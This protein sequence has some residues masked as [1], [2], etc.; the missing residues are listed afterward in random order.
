MP[1]EDEIVR[2]G[3]ES[4]TSSYIK[5][6]TDAVDKNKALLEKLQAQFSDVTA[7][8]EIS[9]KRLNESVTAINKQYGEGAVNLPFFSAVTGQ[10]TDEVVKQNEALNRIKSTIGE[11]TSVIKQQTDAL[12]EAREEA[13]RLR[14]AQETVPIQE[15]VASPGQTPRVNPTVTPTT[16]ETAPAPT[17]AIAATPQPRQ[18]Q[19]VPSYVVGKEERDDALTLKAE[20][21]ELLARQQ[22]TLTGI[23]G[24]MNAETLLAVDA[25]N[26]LQRAMAE[27]SLA[28]SALTRAQKEIGAAASA[29]FAP[30][31]TAIQNFERANTQARSVVTSLEE[32]VSNLTTVQGLAAEGAQQQTA[33]Q[34]RLTYAQGV[35]ARMAQTLAD[36]E[37]EGT[38]TSGSGVEELSALRKRAM[39]EQQV[40]SQALVNVQKEIGAAAAAGEEPAI[41][42]IQLLKTSYA[43]ATRVVNQ[44]QQQIKASNAGVTEDPET[45]MLER[46]IAVEQQVAAQIER[47]AVLQT[48]SNAQSVTG[49]ELQNYLQRA[50]TESGV[51]AR[52][53]AEAQRE[54][55]TSAAQG[56]AQAL[57]I[58]AQLSEA[59]T[60]ARA[61]VDSLKSTIDQYRTS[62][63]GANSQAEA[64]KVATDQLASAQALASRQTETLSALQRELGANSEIS[65]SQMAAIYRRAS[66]ELTTVTSAL[67]N[68]QRE[69]GP[70]AAAGSVEAQAA[71]AILQEQ[72]AKTYEVVNQ[73]GD[74]LK[75]SEAA[76]RAGAEA[77]DMDSVAK[78]QLAA[79]T[80]TATRQT[81]ALDGIQAELN[82]SIGIS[83][84]QLGSVY[85][86][87]AT[88]ARTATTA[89]GNAQRILGPAVA[90]GNQE[91]IQALHLLS[92]A[93]QEAAGYA[94]MLQS[95]MNSLA[96]TEGRTTAAVRMEA[97]AVDAASQAKRVGAAATLEAA[98]A[99]QKL[100]YSALQ[101]FGASRVLASEAGLGGVGFVLSR[102]IS[103]SSILGPLFEALLPI[104][105]VGMAIG[106]FEEWGNK[107]KDINDNY[108]ELKGTMDAVQEVELRMAHASE[109]DFQRVVDNEVSHLKYL[110]QNVEAAELKRQSLQSKPVDLTQVLNDKQI[111]SMK[112]L[113]ED[114]RAKFKNVF[115]DMVAADVP[116]KLQSLSTQLTELE[117]KRDEI[118]KRQS[119]ETDVASPEGGAGFGT[120]MNERYANQVDVA[121]TLYSSAVQ[122]LQ[123][124]RRTFD[125]EWNKETDE[126]SNERGRKLIQ[127]TEE[128]IDIMK[129]S[130][131]Y[132]KEAEKQKWTEVLKQVEEGTTN[133]HTV[134][135]KLGRTVTTRGTE[136][137]HTAQ[138]LRKQDQDELTEM[139]LHGEEIGAERSKV[140]AGEEAYVRDRINAEY[141]YVDNV[142]SLRRELVQILQEEERERIKTENTKAR[143]MV[144]SEGKPDFKSQQDFWNQIATDAKK[145][146]DEYENAVANAQRAGGEAIRAGDE[147]LK[148]DIFASYDAWISATHRTQAEILKFWQNIKEMYSGSG[149]VVEEA[150]RKI[151]EATVKLR[152]ETEK[153]NRLKAEGQD[154]KKIGDLEEE[155]QKAERDSVLF[156]QVDDFPFKPGGRTGKQK[157][158]EIQ[159]NLD[160][161]IARQ[162]QIQ[163]AREVDQAKEEHGDDSPQYQ[164]ALN[165]KAEMDRRY[166]ALS[167]QI[168]TQRL[169]AQVEEYQK[170]FGIIE[171]G[172]N[173]AIDRL[174]D[175]DK[176]WYQ[177]FGDI[178]KNIEKEFAHMLI[179]IAMQW[180]ESKII[181]LILGQQPQQQKN[182]NNG[183]QQQVQQTKNANFQSSESYAGLAASEEFAY[184]IASSAGDIPYAMG[185][186]AIAYGLAQVWAAASQFKEGGLVPGDANMAVPAVLHGKEMVLPNHLSEG[187][188]NLIEGGDTTNTGPATNNVL[189]MRYVDQSTGKVGDPGTNTRNMMIQAKR[190]FKSFNKG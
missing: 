128:E 46:R 155:K 95:Q 35:A 98:G 73:Y 96:E 76:E 169:K 18:P 175:G 38:A 72:Y 24:E 23:T 91:A 53:L 29:N 7:R 97:E 140:L 125:S 20:S 132:T 130:G 58:V 159:Q 172:F 137:D 67:T 34:E 177:S 56:D 150:L 4:D 63:S 81:A 30:A 143:T 171:S 108:I 33:I 86:R 43:D 3:I 69:I 19:Q 112:E 123:D 109:Q 162:R 12:G 176:K 47:L 10:Y 83:S 148:K 164:Q 31:V 11:V 36:I 79:A 103:Q 113:P 15:Q 147:E 107:I 141:K 149:P 156:P 179:N 173:R 170:M 75:A 100:E 186:A 189:N 165:K 85:V 25:Q 62:Q 22:R 131:T 70:A 61:T 90:A 166:N 134:M 5:S 88:E 49:A 87:A 82:K 102:L 57:T 68:A 50:M 127:Q 104:S 106:M 42:A 93:Q 59:N 178:I 152:E 66:T 54:V 40:A 28:T 181:Q 144:T 55:G 52:A 99:E 65:A 145:G 92:V 21:I 119:V 184:A 26:L 133:Y 48:E 94:A 136:T 122:R 168:T 158:I 187:I 116:A 89:L 80:A 71:L 135:Q 6:L 126:V 121:I 160:L 39:A 44:F 118:R 78:E 101:A 13:I 9:V 115:T 41:V 153:Y 111:D 188:Q 32:R 16:P 2:V 60:R 154:Q 167:Y 146:S 37:K 142:R 17:P 161:D 190:G 151:S 163:A 110:G 77:T 124:M 174:I 84:T 114:M 105:L 139:R 64:A 183:Q 14:Q 74:R 1:N 51:A 157:G 27:S 8:V 185:Q 180:L 117:K 129:V 182:A 45:A 138:D 120:S